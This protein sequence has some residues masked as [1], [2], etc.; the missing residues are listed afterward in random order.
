[1]MGFTIS[2]NHR[3]RGGVSASS[4]DGGVRRR[5]HAAHRAGVS[6]LELKH[7]GVHYGMTE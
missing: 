2:R 7:G 5:I 3:S 1:M 6:W 4:R